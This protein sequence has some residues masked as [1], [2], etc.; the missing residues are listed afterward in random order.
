[1]ESITLPLKGLRFPPHDLRE[2]LPQQLLLLKTALEATQGL[3]PLERTRTGV[4]IGMGCDP[5][6]ARYGARWRLADWASQWKGGAPEWLS[7]A[8][9]GA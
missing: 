5:E 2:A 4:F 8:R 9:D 1:M 7:Q 6:V 3:S